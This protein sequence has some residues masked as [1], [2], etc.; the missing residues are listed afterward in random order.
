[1]SFSPS[2][3]PSFHR[4]FVVTEEDQ[5]SLSHWGVCWFGERAN[6]KG[7]LLEERMRGIILKLTR[8][9]QTLLCCRVFPKIESHL[10]S[11]VICNPHCLCLGES[12]TR[13]PCITQCV[14]FCLLHSFSASYRRASTFQRFYMLNCL[15][16]GMVGFCVWFS[17]ECQSAYE[18]QSRV[19]LPSTISERH[20]HDFKHLSTASRCVF[21]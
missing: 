6:C 11:L 9:R 17:D 3:F 15:P 20:V 16:R 4:C 5:C 7:G 18:G 10:M 19:K 8:R 2:V 13:R 21:F 14:M 12:S 1:M